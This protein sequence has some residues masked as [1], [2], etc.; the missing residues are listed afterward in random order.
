MRVQKPACFFHSQPLLPSAPRSTENPQS[1]ISGPEGLRVLQ[2]TSWN[3]KRERGA[4]TTNPVCMLLLRIPWL[5]RDYHL[6]TLGFQPI[7]WELWNDVSPSKAENA[8]WNDTEL[9]TQDQASKARPGIAPLVNITMVTYG[10]QKVQR[11]G[12]RDRGGGREYAMPTTCPWCPSQECRICL[13]FIQ[14]ALKRLTLTRWAPCRVTPGPEETS[15][16]HFNRA[17]LSQLLGHTQ[18]PIQGGCSSESQQMLWGAWEGV[19]KP[20]SA[21]HQPSGPHRGQVGLEGLGL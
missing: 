18:R 12:R 1:W 20:H 17:P 6:Q 2:E 7:V 4:Y 9:S 10:A 16:K 21:W 13:P 19:E 14:T 15:L 3:L 5:Q 8:G 11:I